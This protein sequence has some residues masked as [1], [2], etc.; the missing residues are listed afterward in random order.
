MVSNA[1]A[2]VLT[3][4]G[5]RNYAGLTAGAEGRYIGD[6]YV[7][8][9]VAIGTER[10]LRPVWRPS[11]IPGIVRHFGVRGLRDIGTVGVHNIYISRSQNL[12]WTRTRFFAHRATMWDPQL[13]SLDRL[14]RFKMFEPSASMP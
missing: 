13:S 9:A 4:T 1:V 2:V 14:V 5:I 11:R 7:L 3:V 12:L 8:C 10:D 6:V